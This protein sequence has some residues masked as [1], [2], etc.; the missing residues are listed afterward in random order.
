MSKYFVFHNTEMKIEN[1]QYKN[2][3]KINYENNAHV[4]LR[5]NL[6]TV[7]NTDTRTDSV[8]PVRY[9]SRTGHRLPAQNNPMQWELDT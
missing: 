6:I 4:N 5:E 2:I 9:H 7:C 8:R 1:Q 3:Y